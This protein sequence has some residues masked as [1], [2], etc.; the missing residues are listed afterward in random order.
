MISSAHVKI[1][2]PGPL[3]PFALRAMTHRAGEVLVVEDKSPVIEEQLK[4]ALYRQPVQPLIYGK[5]DRDGRPLIPRHGA[6]TSDIVAKALAHLWR[7]ESLPHRSA[8]P[9][10]V[11]TSSPPSASSWPQRRPPPYAL[12]LLGLP[13][14]HLDPGRRR[15]SWS[16]LVSAATS[17]PPDD[18]GE[19]T[20]SA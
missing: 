19:A 18:E 8:A 17:W 10:T 14:Q 7:D 3:S 15:T 16:G 2:L 4:A 9:W 20:R 6:V 5:E 13:P 11:V 12:L 1:D